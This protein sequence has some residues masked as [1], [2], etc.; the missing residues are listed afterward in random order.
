MIRLNLAKIIFWEKKDKMT[1]L[2]LGLISL[3]NLAALIKGVQF[4]VEPKKET[5]ILEEVPIN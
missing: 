5:C 4:I 3:V 2:F 1:K